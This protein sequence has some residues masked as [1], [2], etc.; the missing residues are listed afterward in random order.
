MKNLTLENLTTHDGVP[1][2]PDGAALVF[3]QRQYGRCEYAALVHP[4]RT[5]DARRVFDRNVT[6]ALRSRLV[7]LLA[8]TSCTV[9]LPL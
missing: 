6:S 2:E 4:E 7:E 3:G 1:C 9:F 8:H 5:Y